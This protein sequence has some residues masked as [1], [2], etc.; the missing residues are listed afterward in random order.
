MNDPLG[1]QRFVEWNLYP[2]MDG[3][4]ADAFAQLTTFAGYGP[5]VGGLE[6][7]LAAP[8]IQGPNCTRH[9]AVQTDDGFYLHRVVGPGVPP[10]SFQN[11]FFNWVNGVGVG[12]DTQQ[13]QTD[14]LPVGA[15]T[16]SICP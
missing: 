12:P 14:N 13:I 4:W 3:Y 7:P 11:L 8:G 15:Y 2:T 16:P 5:G 9:V 10:R 6:P 1:Q